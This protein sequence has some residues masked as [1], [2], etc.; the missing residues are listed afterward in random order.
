[1]L[2]RIIKRLFIT[3]AVLALLG[4]GFFYLI[5]DW[6]GKPPCHLAAG[7]QFRS[8]LQEQ[9]TQT[10]P[11][12]NG[13][14]ADSLT[15]MQTELGSL[16]SLQIANHY[17][18]V[19]GLHGDDPGDLVLLYFDQPTRYTHHVSL[20]T[21][22]E[23]KGWVIMQLDFNAGSSRRLPTLGTGE[24]CVR[25]TTAEFKRRLK[26]TLEFL[27]ANNRPH[28]QAVV[29]EHTAFLEGLEKKGL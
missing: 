1:M 23:E 9:G 22:F 17:R 4:T 27:R 20:P 2:W 10:F 14:S 25:V 28:W 12:V 18:Y 6:T 11:N 21:V 3:L 24:W 16:E 5:L 8:W 19:P 15:L 13:L 26:E 29:A 7:M